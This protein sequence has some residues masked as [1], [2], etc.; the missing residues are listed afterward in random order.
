[1]T[2]VHLRLIFGLISVASFILVSTFASASVTTYLRPNADRTTSEPWT[3][4]GA[5]QAWEALDDPVTE[6]ETPGGAD[7]ISATPSQ[8]PLSTRLDLSTISL[9]GQTILSGTAWI[10][11]ATATSTQLIVDPEGGGHS[12]ASQTFTGTGW[13]SLSI[14]LSALKQSGLNSLNIELNTGSGSGIRQV[15]AALVRLT[16]E[17]PS[18]SIYWGAWMDGDVYTPPGEPAWGDAPWDSQTWNTFES[19]AGRAPSLVHFG[20]PAP[21]SQS[22]SAEPLT[23]AS[24]RGAI[25]LMD[26]NSNG[27]TLA[28]I[29]LGERDEPLIS[30]LKAVRNFEKPFFFRWDWEMNGTWFNWGKEAAASSTTFVAAWRHFHNLAEE[31]GATNITWVWCPN[32]EFNGSTSLKNLYPGKAYVDWTC[33][34]GYNRGEKAPGTNHEWSNFNNVFG[35]TYASLLSVAPTKPIMIGETASTESGGSKASWIEDAFGTQIP[36]NFPN[37]KAVA[38]FNWNFFDKE[39]NLTWDWQIESSAS[40]QAAFANIISSP[41]YASNSFGSMTPL[42]RIKPLP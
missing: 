21:W 13:H 28:E 15:S 5:S 40:A 37:I 26:M 2:R 16:I 29:A 9:A 20:Q 38:W 3:I 17:P 42:S 25:P 12:V 36:T 1:M 10:Y 4:V 23:L 41:Y 31:Y 22:F 18:H 32:T 11:M 27:A 24:S 19:H 8:S 33:M 30:W 39:L 34:D 14:P 35:T 7:Y 6:I